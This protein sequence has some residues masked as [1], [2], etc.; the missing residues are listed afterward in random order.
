MREAHRWRALRWSCPGNARAYRPWN[1][2]AARTSTRANHHL[3]A[4]DQWGTCCP[5][6]PPR[7]FRSS[8]VIEGWAS[9]RN[10]PPDVFPDPGHP[11]SSGREASP[12]DLTPSLALKDGRPYMGSG[13][14]ART[15]RPWSLQFPELRGF[16]MNLQ[17]ASSPHVP[18]GSFPLSF[19][20]MA[21]SPGA[22]PGGP[23]PRETVA[24]LR[25]RGT[26]CGWV[27]LEPRPVLGI[28]FDA[29]T[30]RSPARRHGWRPVRHRLVIPRDFCRIFP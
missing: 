19:T 29:D 14:L 4:M 27:G 17:V 7:W 18:Y 23:H 1:D 16:G 2:K 20:R 25:E 11:N 3:D 30:A 26:R 5:Q 8:P 10:P 28:R 21:R 9:P 24:F 6:P 15:S 13:L 12:H 22:L